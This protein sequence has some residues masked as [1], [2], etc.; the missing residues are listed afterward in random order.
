MEKQATGAENVVWDLSVLYAGLDD[1]KIE[2]DM[3]HYMGQV[4]AFANDYRGKVGQLDPEELYE[5][6]ERSEGLY[7]GAGKIISFASLNYSTDT[8]DPKR[9]ALMQKATEFYSGINQQMLFFMLEWNLL[10]EDHAKKMMANPTLEKYAHHLEAERIYT[11]YQLSES[12]ERILSEKS[13]TGN[14]AWV[15]FFTQLTSSMRYDFDGE[16]LSQTKLMTKL[17]SPDRETRKKAADAMTAGLHSKKMELTYIYN[18]IVADK[19]SN[20]KLRGYPT[21]ISSRNLDNKAPDAVVDALVNSVTSNYQLVSRH[22]TLKRVLLGLD[23]LAD[24]DRYAPLPFDDVEEERYTWAEAKEIILNAFNAFS[25]EM[26]EVAGYFF[27]K[28]WIHAAVLPNKRGGAYASPVTPSA[29]PFVFVNFEGRARDVATLAHELGHGIHMYLSGKASGLL[30]L[31]TPLTTAEMA[32]VFGE[33][34]VFSDLMN[35]ETRPKARLAMLAGKIEDTFATVF[36]QTSMNRF[37]HGLHTARRTEGELP[38]DR[39]NAI[40]MESQRAMFG[41]SVN[42]RDEYSQ[43]WSYI[44]HF[45]STPGY[46]YAYA[47]GELL[48]LALYQIYL[49][50]GASFAPKYLDVLAAGNSDYPDKIL[51]KV[52]VDLNDPNFWQKGLDAISVL[53]DQEEALAKEVYPD[54]F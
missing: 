10:P 5:A 23:E 12:E 7:D 30:G 39:I 21:W 46:V 4:Q 34:L 37:E 28:N 51:A 41:D 52:G 9:G 11:P 1:P 50:Q 44:P 26:A 2:A 22:Y 20:D 32:S 36:R 19:A 6:M 31:Y 3:T 13:V 29:H 16:Q 38:T 54:R 18:T 35:R 8:A 33:M 17:Y 48:V 47:F 40:W 53:I 43:W 42:L 15:R 14:S 24:Y 25:P 49:E 27:D 45:L